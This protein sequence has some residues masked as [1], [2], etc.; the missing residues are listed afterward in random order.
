MLQIE[1][2]SVDII[3]KPLRDEHSGDDPNEQTSSPL[4][5]QF[6]LALTLF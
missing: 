5:V 3:E 1:Y 4:Q 6:L 2:R